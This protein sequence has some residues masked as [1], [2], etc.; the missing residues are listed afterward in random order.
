MEITVKHFDSGR[1]RIDLADWNW[2]CFTQQNV[3]PK[4]VRKVTTM[5]IKKYLAARYT[6]Q[7]RSRTSKTI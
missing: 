7:A 6:R 4:P 3:L 2:I 5:S 1:R